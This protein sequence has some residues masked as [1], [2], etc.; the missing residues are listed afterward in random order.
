MCIQTN[1]KDSIK[2]LCSLLQGRP[3]SVF[4]MDVTKILKFYSWKNNCS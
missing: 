3:D 4:S 2:S 1:V